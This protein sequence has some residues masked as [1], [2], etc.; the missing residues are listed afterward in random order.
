MGLFEKLF[1]LA[2]Q[3]QEE[4]KKDRTWIAKCELEN[5]AVI[6]PSLPENLWYLL[7]K[8]THTRG[9]EGKWYIKGGDYVQ[10]EDIIG[11]P[12]A[13]GPQLYTP[14][15][16]RIVLTGS[17]NTHGLW[18]KAGIDWNDRTL[19][20]QPLKGA[21]TQDAVRLTF[22][23]VIEFAQTV[24]DNPKN[25]R[26]FFQSLKDE[27]AFFAQLDREITMIH[28]TKTMIAPINNLYGQVS[29]ANHFPR[30]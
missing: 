10:N 6:I 23:A 27:K 1:G 26:E 13:S 17:F 25:Y 20:I 9:S 8:A 28:E 24:R 29:E 22:L 11:R 7:R 12:F 30:P 4:P 16:G 14:F 2:S 19:T 3:P 5:F 21:N 18:T 15:T